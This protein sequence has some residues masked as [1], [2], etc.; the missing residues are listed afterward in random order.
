VN[1]LIR[2]R[3]VFGQSRILYPK[4]GAGLAGGNWAG[5]ENIFNSVLYGCDHTLCVLDTDTAKVV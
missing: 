1:A 3:G 2:I 4:I 5:L